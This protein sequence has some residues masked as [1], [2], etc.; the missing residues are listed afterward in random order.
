ML[1]AQVS[2]PKT[3]MAGRDVGENLVAGV[4]KVR[5]CPHEHHWGFPRKQTPFPGVALLCLGPLSGH[6]SALTLSHLSLT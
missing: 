2:L 6:L 5:L 3:P 1:L 4:G